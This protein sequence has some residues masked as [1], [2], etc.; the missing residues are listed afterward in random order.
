MAGVDMGWA[1]QQQQQQP[2]CLLGTVPGCTACCWDN[3]GEFLLI[4]V[5]QSCRR[6]GGLTVVGVG[7]GGC[8]FD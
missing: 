6:R 1:Q 8:Q 3:D 2:P 4:E 5:G 7:V